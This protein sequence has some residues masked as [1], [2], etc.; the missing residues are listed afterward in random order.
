MIVKS[1]FVE[2]RN[3]KYLK[4][5]L[6]GSEIAWHLNKVLFLDKD[7][8]YHQLCN[9]V[10]DQHRIIDDYNFNMLLPLLNKLEI[11]SLLRIKCNL[12]FKTKDI[13]EHGFHTDYTPAHIGSKT[14]IFYVNTNN[15]YTKLEDNTIISSEENKI[16]IINGDTKHTGTTCSDAEFRVVININYF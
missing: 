11:R 6:L 15:G 8:N 16:C 9:V 5:F 7:C 1:N 2:E 14:A 10:Y 3:F 13:I 12:L 4:K